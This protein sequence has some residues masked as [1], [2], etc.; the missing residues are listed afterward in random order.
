M[1]HIDTAWSKL[2]SRTA[3]GLLARKGGTYDDVALALRGLGI[4]ET[5]KAVEQKIQRGTLKCSLFL[6]LIYVLRAD[7]PADLHRILDSSSGWDDACRR[8]AQ[9]LL[10]ADSSIS[11]KLLSHQLEECGTRLSPAQ[12]DSQLQSGVYAFSLLLQLAYLYPF[13]PLER[14]VD[15]SDLEQAAKEARPATSQAS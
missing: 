13:P 2:A 7:V 1:S 6:Q 8:L 15:R 14:F 12:I 10:I 11:S 5:T 3:R 4:E 9:L